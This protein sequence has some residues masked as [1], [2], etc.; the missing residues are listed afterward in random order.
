MN[1]KIY[2]GKFQ[3]AA[4]GFGFVLL[5]EDE[6]IFVSKQ[7]K[8][9]A[10]NG[11]IVRVKITQL[12]STKSKAEGKIIGIE[13]R[14]VTTFIGKV[15]KS[16]KAM[17]VIPDNPKYT[18]D[19]FIPKGYSNNAKNGDKVVVHIDKYAEKDRKAEG[20]ILKVLN[21]IKDYPID[22]LSIL[23]EYNV[24]YEWNDNI[25]KETKK[26]PLSV[27]DN[28]IKGRYDFRNQDTITIDGSD[29]KDV[30]DAIYL[31]KIED[32][33]RLYVHIADV[34]HYVKFNS[35]IDKEAEERGT[36][37][38]LINSVIPMLPKELSNGICSLNEGV[39][40]LTLTC[41]MD[42]DNF[43][44]VVNSNI[45]EGVIKVKYHMTYDSVQNIFDGIEVNVSDN[46]KNMINLM[47]E[48]S[49]KIDIL[50]D[51]KG[52]ID[53]DTV[54]SKY[55]FNKKGNIVDVIP[56]ER[57]QSHR[58][59]ENFMIYANESVATK[60]F[61]R[62][63]PFIYRV[64][65]EPSEEKIEEL[66]KVLNNMNIKTH[67]GNKIYSGQLKKL[68]DKYSDTPLAV[69]LNMVVLKSMMRAKYS[70][71][72]IGHFGLGLSYYSHFTS[73]IRRYSDL[74]I[75]R[76]IK[77]VINTEVQKYNEESLI[78]LANKITVNQKKSDDCQREYEKI[79]KIEFMSK[80]I[81]NT[82]LGNI[83]HITNFGIYVSMENTVEGMIR[84]KDIPFDNFIY[85]VDR[86]CVVGENYRMEYKIGDSVRVKIIDAS[87][88]QRTLDLMFVE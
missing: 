50:R 4:K 72:A 2:I 75:H 15:D 23:E 30:D 26:I 78:T 59:I 68:L 25:I 82:Y 85:D 69:F 1:N 87:L 19:V 62:G 83:S 8:L 32:S 9:N 35:S 10:M 86:N 79:K 45:V 20:S 22:V 41:I 42:I 11:D 51:K 52:N 55:K 17:F 31:E 57:L 70:T 12:S 28:E 47:R 76:I 13:S 54:E 24:R 14:A 18:Q 64:H 81:G 36:S 65:E 3:E 44:K 74:I 80:H 48:L 6:D 60:Y 71:E 16:K 88:R 7:N 77:A 66:I 21:R 84:I 58:I 67:F 73:P 29:T 61:W 40:R 33:Y 43:G 39:D 37:V 49:E 34:S 56:F 5:E 27:S 53:F 46:T 38:Y 63:I